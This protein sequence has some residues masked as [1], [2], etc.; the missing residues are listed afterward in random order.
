MSGER[1][2][3]GLALFFGFVLLP[4]LHSIKCLGAASAP[5]SHKRLDRTG[6]PVERSGTEQLPGTR[7]DRGGG[8][9]SGKAR[10]IKSFI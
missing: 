8:K 3:K 7:P 6:L 10:P 2:R 5:P 4:L 9:R 1:A